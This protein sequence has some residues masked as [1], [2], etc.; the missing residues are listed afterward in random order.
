MVQ[1]LPQARTAPLP[2]PFLSLSVRPVLFSR[3][4]RAPVAASHAPFHGTREVVNVLAIRN[5]TGLVLSHSTAPTYR[6]RPPAD[7]APITEASNR[8]GRAPHPC[9]LPSVRRR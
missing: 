9:R 6:D 7:P 1:T 2:A 3:R 8:G 4:L 5:F